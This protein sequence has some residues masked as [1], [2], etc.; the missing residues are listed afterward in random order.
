MTQLPVC[1]TIATDTPPTIGVEDAEPTVAAISAMIGIMIVVLMAPAPAL[2]NTA[3]LMA[4]APMAAMTVKLVRQVTKLLPPSPI[5]KEA[6]SPA[7]T[8]YDA[9]G[10]QNCLT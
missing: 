10:L 4:P 2:V 3:G 7:A 1:Q 6:V 5:C 8:G 9:S